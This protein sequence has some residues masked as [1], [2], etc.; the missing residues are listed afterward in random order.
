VRVIVALRHTWGGAVGTHDARSW[1]AGGSR[2]GSVGN[3]V[4][5]FERAGAIVF[6]IA[7]V[8]L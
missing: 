8:L 5:W 1:R 3:V 6:L 7:C 2:I 4:D